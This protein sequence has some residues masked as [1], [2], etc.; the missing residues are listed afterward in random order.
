M[1]RA[2]VP[3]PD[4]S[5]DGYEW[6]CDET[7]FDPSIH[8]ALEK[9]TQIRYLEEFGYSEHEIAS[10]ATAVAV[11]SPFRILSDEG[12]RVMLQ[13]TRSL[14]AHA[15]SC[16]RIENMVRGG[17]YRSKFLRDLCIEPSVTD[18][19][20]DVYGVDIAPH[21]MPLHLGHI[22]FS[23]DD[24]NKAVDK[25]H[26]DTLPLDYVMMV[27]DPATLSGGKFEYFVGTK[28]EMAELA[29][30]GETP[31]RDRVVA[32]YFPGP[33]YAI[34][35]HGDM[36]AHRGGSLQKPGERITM[37]NGYVSTDTHGDDQNRHKDLTLV[38][39]PQ[40]LYT[41]WAKHAAWRARGRLDNLLAEIP[42]NP[43]AKQVAMLLEEAIKDVSQT[44]EE[45]RNDE[46][47]QMHHYERSKT[48]RAV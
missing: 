40:V 11:T 25:W 34:A 28:Q 38:D 22:N 21:T 24:L 30:R 10:K 41:E 42:F 45:M 13:V 14:R 9:P 5:P 36:I 1:S 19:L 2:A 7:L 35:L 4:S 27:S 16:E 43:D 46:E 3:F 29:S 37:V 20:C 15:I 48:K 8:L 18:L 32:P 26:H 39:D 23:P 33:G 12:S 6:F 17:C 47:H 31:P 44:I